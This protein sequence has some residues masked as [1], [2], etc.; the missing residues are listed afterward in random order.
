M[1]FTTLE[2]TEEQLC[3]LYGIDQNKEHDWKFKDG[4][5]TRQM[6]KYTFSKRCI[7]E[8]QLFGKDKSVVP[9]IRKRFKK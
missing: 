5:Y 2:I 7:T 3:R 9:P 4:I 1:N 8:E 6:G